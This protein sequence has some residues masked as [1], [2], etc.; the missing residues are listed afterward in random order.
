MRTTTAPRAR[1]LAATATGLALTMTVSACHVGSK[2][3]PSQTTSASAAASE[4]T[5][6][7]TPTAG[8]S[9]SLPAGSPAASGAALRDPGSYASDLQWVDITKQV[10]SALGNAT[11]RKLNFSRSIMKVPLDWSRPDGGKTVSITVLRV[12]SSSQHDRIGSLVINPGGPGGSG[13]EAAL[14]LAAEGLPQEIVDRF[15][16]VGFDPRGVGDSDPITCIPAKEKDADLNLPA[17]PSTDAQWNVT[18]AEDQK[19]ADE[20][21][22]T[23]GSDLTHYSTA[24]TVRDMEALRA[25]LGDAKL[26]YLGYSYGTLLGAEYASA[27]PDRVRALVLDGAI[28]PTISTL[29][30]DKIQAEGFELAFDHYAASCEQ[31]SS[32]PLGKNPVAFVQNLMTTSD[33]HPIPSG[34][35]K[36]TRVVKGGAVLLAV[37]SALYDKSQWSD[38]TSAL[39]NA[40]NGDGSG[41]LALD[42]QYNERNPDGSYSNIE[43]ANS[44]ISCA[45]T[46]DRTSV[47]EARALQPQWRAAAPLMGGAEAA[48]TAFCS[49]W[50]APPDKPITVVDNHA[51]T[52]LVV[53]TTGDPATPIS[54][55]QHLARLLGSGDLLV[56]QGDGHTAYPKTSCITNAVDGYLIDLKAPPAGTT[57]PAS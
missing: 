18:V 55:A 24:E 15:D 20:C 31:Q 45:D 8:G 42:D 2:G 10:Q 41:V 4:Q 37:I 44:A 57:C 7:S 54:G 56:W 26:T 27:Y 34:S 16:I 46:T 13:L 23:Y 14:E 12:R 11:K 36:D 51:P 35:A 38:L 5:T 50:K 39:R 48:G 30:Q 9:A 28:D 22:A 19:I 47:A 32:C 49:L 6:A 3:S 1:R 33:V 17:D 43:D 53:G 21:Y 40:E 52:V 25:K 29:T